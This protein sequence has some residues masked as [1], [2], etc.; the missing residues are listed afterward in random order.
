MAYYRPGLHL[1]AIYPV[2]Q[3]FGRGIKFDFDGYFSGEKTFLESY[4]QNRL[5]KTIGYQIDREEKFVTK[6]ILSGEVSSCNSGQ[7]QLTALNLD[8][9]TK[10]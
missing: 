2:M 5:Q 4:D 7:D 10:R 6:N 3:T 1:E 9:C 8:F